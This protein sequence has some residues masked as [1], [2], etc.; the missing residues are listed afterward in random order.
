MGYDFNCSIEVLTY[1]ICIST[2]SE[3][4]P[5]VTRPG[6]LVTQ[7]SQ[8]WQSDGGQAAGPL[9]TTFVCVHHKL[10]AYQLCSPSLLRKYPEKLS[11][12]IDPAPLAL[13]SGQ[14]ASD[15]ISAVCRNI[16]LICVKIGTK[17]YICSLLFLD[18]D[19]KDSLR[20]NFD[21]VTSAIARL[22][23]CLVMNSISGVP[24]FCST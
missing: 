13:A 6:S 21:K 19:K 9:L 16:I 8:Y 7:H 15:R 22:E 10:S 4:L 1:Q 23:M 20:L 2:S 24:G 17:L 14:S 3:V 11:S 12:N 18:I 5:S